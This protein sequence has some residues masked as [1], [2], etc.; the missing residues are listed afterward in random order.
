MDAINT[1]IERGFWPSLMG[2]LSAARSPSPGRLKEL[3][4]QTIFN[5]L[6][7]E[8][9]AATV[10]E[11][12]RQARLAAASWYTGGPL[13]RVGAPKVALPAPPSLSAKPGRFAVQLIAKSVE[14]Q[15]RRPQVSVPVTF[16]ADGPLTFQEAVNRLQEFLA[17]EACRGTSPSPQE[18]EEAAN[19][20]DA[21][22]EGRTGHILPDWVVEIVFG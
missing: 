4:A 19:A 6:I 2:Y 21:W 13:E 8:A 3:A 12:G 22:L 15:N 7:S 10:L 17:S 11:M 5:V 14:T 16:A 20:V 9:E 1:L 18:C